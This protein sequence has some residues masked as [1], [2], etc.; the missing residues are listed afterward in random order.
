LSDARD[1]RIEIERINHEKTA[2]KNFQ[3]DVSSM[4]PGVSRAAI[5]RSSD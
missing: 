5:L 2:E 3:I 4:C 1:G